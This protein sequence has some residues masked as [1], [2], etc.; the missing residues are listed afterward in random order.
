MNTV[1]DIELAI[2][3]LNDQDLGKL[4]GWFDDYLA[5]KWESRFKVDA[6]AGRVDKLGEAA[7]WAFERG[8]CRP[9]DFP[10]ILV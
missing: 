7:D 8:L 10:E 4:S 5:E 2:K 1:R 3:R 6:E 9:L